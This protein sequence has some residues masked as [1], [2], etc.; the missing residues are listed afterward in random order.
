MA[1]IQNFLCQISR[2]GKELSGGK[3]EP[4]LNLPRI[5]G[6]LIHFL[7]LLSLARVDKFFFLNAR[8]QASKVAV[9]GRGTSYHFANIP[10][11]R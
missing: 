4:T 10:I 8:H 3:Y 11:K 5:K 2:G 6:L 1:K 9:L 7:I